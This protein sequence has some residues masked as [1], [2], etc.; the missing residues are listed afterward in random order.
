MANIIERDGV[1]VAITCPV[2]QK[3][4][5]ISDFR[6]NGAWLMMC[7]SC[8]EKRQKDEWVLQRVNKPE[9]KGWDDVAMDPCVSTRG[10]CRNGEW[11]NRFENGE[12]IF[13][14]LYCVQCEGKGVQTYRDVLRNASYNEWDAYRACMADEPETD[15]ER[16]SREHQEEQQSYGAPNCGVCGQYPCECPVDLGLDMGDPF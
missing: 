6:D 2:C 16:T 15:S 12:P 9:S 3:N 4:R 14:G 5:A 8:L 7:K 11:T 13:K 10:L 1:P